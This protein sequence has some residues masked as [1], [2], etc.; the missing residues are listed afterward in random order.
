VPC[1]RRREAGSR[2]R[3]NATFSADSS[4]RSRPTRQVGRCKASPVTS[5]ALQEGKGS[6]EPHQSRP[7]SRCLPESSSSLR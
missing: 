1:R 4:S 2:Q 5:V 3:Q 7:R 6:K